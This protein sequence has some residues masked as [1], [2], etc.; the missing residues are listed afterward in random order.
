MSSEASNKTFK[1][2]LII[3]LFSV[4][5][6]Y[7]E[8]AVVVYLRQ[9]F[10]SEGFTFPLKNFGLSPLWKKL[11]LIEIGREAATIVL[12]LTG[13]CLAGRSL[14]QKFAYFMAIFGIWDIFFY[15]WLKIF[16]D[17]PSSIVD[18]DVLF[19]IPMVWAGPV[20]AP[21]VISVILLAF[22]IIILHRSSRAI[23]L[24]VTLPDWLG[25]I[26]CGVI[27]V[28]SF[29]IA[30]LHMTKPNFQSHFYWLLF[31]VGCIAAVALFIK[32]LLKSPGQAPLQS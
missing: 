3:V 6:A 12:I 16:L 21:V 31:A 32:C 30:G 15:I 17:W 29:C 22:A 5:F 10:H 8:A 4:A 24:K 28:V 23:Q 13:A 20:L 1:T 9:I 11:L 7:I 18:W 14:Q 2:F 26:L 27:V 19:L 25:F